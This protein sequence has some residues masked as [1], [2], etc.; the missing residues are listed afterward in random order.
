MTQK[1][2]IPIDPIY[3]LFKNNLKSKKKYFVFVHCLKKNC[4]NLEII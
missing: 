3:F 2:S 4:L 1:M